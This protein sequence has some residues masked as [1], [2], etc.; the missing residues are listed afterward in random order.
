MADDQ[1]ERR[2]ELQEKL[3][4]YRILEQE[5]TDPVAT[6]FLQ[7][8]VLELESGLKATDCPR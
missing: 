7:E 1:E 2:A 6:R 3:M 8:I 4:R 5:T